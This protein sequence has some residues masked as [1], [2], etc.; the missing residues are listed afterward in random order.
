[1][2]TKDELDSFIVAKTDGDEEMAE[3]IAME[4]DKV[5]MAGAPYSYDP[6][7]FKDGKG[8]VVLDAD[9]NKLGDWPN[10]FKPLP[11][12]AASRSGSYGFSYWGSL[13]DPSDTRFSGYWSSTPASTAPFKANYMMIGNTG[14]KV[15][16][17]KT[18][19]LVGLSV[20]CLK[21]A[22]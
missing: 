21:N 20:R 16:S 2:P 13:S 7:A 9:G 6:D 8:N 5:W 11:A 1:M 12:G 19:D 4:I 22:N 17:E 10:K 18:A 15:A 14:F 3:L